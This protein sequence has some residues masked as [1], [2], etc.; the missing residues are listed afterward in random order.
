M[1]TI[2]TNAITTT[3]GK[4]ILQ[5]TGSILQVVN[6]NT[7]GG[8]GEITTTSSAYVNSGLSVSIT[9]ISS[10]SRLFVQWAGNVK[11]VG[12][13]GDNGIAIRMYRD[14]V[15]INS[16]NDNLFYRSDAGAQNHHT[17]CCINHY[18]NANST[19]ATTFSIW[20]SAQWEGTAVITRDWGTCQFTVWEISA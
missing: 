1:S 4:T 17:S 20:F 9:P 11:F 19:A 2:R 16:T 14:N 8:S 3:A 10:S 12:G 5:S 15:T 13:G 6:N 7:L 18:V